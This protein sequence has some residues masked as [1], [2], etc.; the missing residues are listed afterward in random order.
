MSR[1]YLRFNSIN[2]EN[3]LGSN[4]KTAYDKINIYDGNSSSGTLLETLCGNIQSY[5]LE[6][7]AHNLY[8]EFITDSR[9]QL[10]GFHASYTFIF[11]TTTTFSTTTS[12]TSANIGAKTFKYDEIT[13][14]TD[15]YMFNMNMSNNSV[16]ENM[17][18]HDEII[19]QL[20]ASFQEQPGLD[21]I[22]T[23]NSEPFDPDPGITGKCYTTLFHYRDYQG[24]Y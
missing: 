18:L 3:H 4:C 2:L 16:S 1:I 23:N 17:A 10:T 24:H 8:I 7:T 5:S 19:V 21:G 22:E 6:S 12:T 13:N 20:D 11:Q 14:H 15:E 9:V